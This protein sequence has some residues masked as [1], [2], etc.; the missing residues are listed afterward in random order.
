MLGH[1]SDSGN[2]IGGS[3]AAPQVGRRA[4]GASAPEAG[5]GSGRFEWDKRGGQEGGSR[6]GLCGPPG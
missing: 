2:Q 6:P 3:E 5:G 1:G 4:L